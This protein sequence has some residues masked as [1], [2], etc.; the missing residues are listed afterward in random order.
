MSATTIAVAERPIE[1]LIK[2]MPGN[3]QGRGRTL[4]ERGV[5]DG[6]KEAVIALQVMLTEDSDPAHAMLI[7]SAWADSCSDNGDST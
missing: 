7:I 1:E 5:R 2:G 6:K 3:Q 4:Y